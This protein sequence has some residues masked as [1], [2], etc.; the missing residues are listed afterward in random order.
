MK[1][2][3]CSLKFF[4][5]QY[6]AIHEIEFLKKYPNQYPDFMLPWIKELESWELKDLAELESFPNENLVKDASFK[7]F[8]KSI[9]ELTN[10]RKIDLEEAFLP[11]SLKKKMSPKKKHEIS[12]LKSIV[13]DLEIDHIIDIGGGVGYLSSALVLGRD[14]EAICVDKDFRLQETGRSKV[15]AWSLKVKFENL[16]FNKEAELKSH[17]TPASSLLISL[18]GC[19]ALSSSVIQFAAQKKMS[20]LINLGCCYHKLDGQYN[21]SEHSKINPVI[22]T[23]NALHLASR[24][25]SIVDQKALVDRYGFKRYRYTLHYFLNDHY[26]TEFK[27]L[28]NAK[29]SDYRGRFSDYAKKFCT[30]GE[31]D[32]VSAKSLDEFYNNDEV[33]RKFKQNFIAD[34]IRLFLG[35]LIELYIVLDRAIFLE[36]QGRSVKLVEIFDRQLSPRNIMIESSID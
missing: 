18:H 19:G 2:H 13:D 32:L 31:L 7:E 10:L 14:T 34:M 20:H 36:E 24:C 21:L 6:S 5:N 29:G 30:E 15:K 23:T 16:E 33:E 3:F 25:G 8:L 4:L 12:L 11:D 1:D 22:F 28:G 9:R 27:S 35:R 17:F 26:Q